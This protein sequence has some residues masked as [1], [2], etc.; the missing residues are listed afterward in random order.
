MSL[1][2]EVYRYTGG[3]KVCDRYFTPLP[4]CH[5]DPINPSTDVEG[6]LELAKS[7]PGLVTPDVIHDV[8]YPPELLTFLKKLCDHLDMIAEYKNDPVCFLENFPVADVNMVIADRPVMSSVVE[9]WFQMNP[10]DPETLCHYVGYFADIDGVGENRG[11]LYLDLHIG[12]YVISPSS[13]YVPS[14]V[15]DYINLPSLFCLL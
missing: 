1:V 9:Q 8:S 4:Q 3:V 5:P 13:Q 12:T 7:F 14:D 6:E 10:I 11:C 2:A 15:R